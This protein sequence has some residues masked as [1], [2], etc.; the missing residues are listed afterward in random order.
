MWWSRWW[1]QGV[2]CHRYSLLVTINDDFLNSS[3]SFIFHLGNIAGVFWG[4]VYP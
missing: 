3:Y 1:P 4:E 2:T